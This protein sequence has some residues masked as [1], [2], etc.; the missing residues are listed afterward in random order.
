MGPNL[1]AS[2][3]NTQLV[4]LPGFRSR[5]I[6]LTRQRVHGAS[7][8]KRDARPYYS[9]ARC[10]HFHL[11]GDYGGEL[12]RGKAAFDSR[13]VANINRNVLEW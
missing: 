12:V 3:R 10:R 1:R 9:A 13:S 6:I 5:A 7:P 11:T 2:G 4:R 8:A